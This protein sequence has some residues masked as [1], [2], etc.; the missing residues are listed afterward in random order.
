MLLPVLSMLAG[1]VLLTGGAEGL[2]QGAASLAKR[3]GLSPL[4]I[5]LTVV[6]LGTSM[7]ELV[8]SLEA[9][10]RG[11]G[12]LSL[13]NVVG[14]NIANIGLILG[15]A[16]LIRALHVQ[17]QVI[18]FDMPILS[19]VSLGMVALVVD[20]QISRIDGAVLT[21]GLGTYIVVSIR[22]ARAEPKEAVNE[23]FGAALPTLHR[24]SIDLL[25]LGLGLAGLVI[26]ARFLIDGAVSLAQ[27]W[28][29]SN[30]VI[31]LTVVAVGTSLPEL[32]TSL[33]AAWRGEGD[34]A[35]GNAVGSCIFNLLGIL[36][37]TALVHPLDAGELSLIDGAVMLGLTLFLLPLMRTGFAL[38]RLEGGLLLAAYI[39]YMAFL[40]A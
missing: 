3:F 4:V 10:L 5:G 38:S 2:V 33:V 16:A 28:N 29:V 13:G 8:V 31:G 27:Q 37:I 18:R 21:F 34:I 40:I 1:L 20:G 6:A 25:L 12:A 19:A 9:A 22:W 32:A 15:V 11:D 26:G 36:G 23:V 30:V 17:A 14:S 35:V 39:G 7:P 24:W